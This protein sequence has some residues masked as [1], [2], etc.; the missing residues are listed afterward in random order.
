MMR[1]NAAEPDRNKFNILEWMPRDLVAEEKKA[2]ALKKKKAVNA[3]EGVQEGEMELH[4]EDDSEE[5]EEPVIDLAKIK[6]EK[7]EA[8]RLEESKR[9]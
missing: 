1:L 2:A 7:E 5:K 8:E 9:Q 6:Q 3:E 4:L